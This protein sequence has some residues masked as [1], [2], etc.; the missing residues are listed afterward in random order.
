M[1]QPESK[2]SAEILPAI[3]RHFLNRIKLFRNQVGQAWFGGVQKCL[4]PGQVYRAKGGEV[5]LIN[6]RRYSC[7][8]IKGSGD[9]IGWEEVT[10]TQ[11]M[12]GQKFARFVSLETKV[13]KSGRVSTEQKHWYDE[14]KK[15]G[16]RAVV[17]RSP[18]DAIRG[19][20]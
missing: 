8:L 15:A 19:L 5:L 11:E 20:K 4:K 14:V 2:L 3:T 13:P 17:A 10:I 1:T 16:G 12:V 7:G 9:N 6:A 18:D